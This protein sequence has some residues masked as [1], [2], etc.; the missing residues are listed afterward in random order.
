MRNIPSPAE[1][2]DPFAI[3]GSLV[4][5]CA[6]AVRCRVV[7]S[8]GVVGGGGASYTS[9]ASVLALDRIRVLSVGLLAAR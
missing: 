2:V 8:S 6:K 4:K 7:Q 5:F 1:E 9:C 3:T